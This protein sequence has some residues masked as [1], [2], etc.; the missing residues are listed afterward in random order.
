MK[1]DAFVIAPFRMVLLIGLCLCSLGLNAQ[2]TEHPF[3]EQAR[4]RMADIFGE[5]EPYWVF[6]HTLRKAVASHDAEAVAAMA[7]YPL[8]LD[9]HPDG[10][11]SSEAEFV[12]GYDRIFTP[13]LSRLVVETPF[14]A[15][16][17]NWRGIAFGKGELWITGYIETCDCH[18]CADRDL[19]IA[20]FA[21]NPGLYERLAMDPPGQTVFEQPFCDDS[22]RSGEDD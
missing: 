9:G 18:P 11:I 13:S 10:E 7:R 12:E 17:I 1:G 20:I 19:R 22:E 8:Y 16:L 4:Q 5:P 3:D 14:N 2:E 15:L 6:L 21:I